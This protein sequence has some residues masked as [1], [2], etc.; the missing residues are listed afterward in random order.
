MDRTILHWRKEKEKKAVRLKPKHC[1][2][3]ANWTNQIGTMGSLV[4]T[5]LQS[6]EEKFNTLQGVAQRLNNIAKI[7]KRHIS[8]SWSNKTTHCLNLTVKAANW[9]YSCFFLTQRQVFF[10][11]KTLIP[12]GILGPIS[13]FYITK[14]TLAP[15]PVSLTP[16]YTDKD[17]KRITRT[18]TPSLS[19]SLTSERV[20]TRSA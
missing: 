13:C 8:L 17:S 16:S 4:L 11:L 1:N 3:S 18:L 5:L 2:Y 15:F 14:N 9:K 12:R 7:R 20:M 19:L 6:S 10:F